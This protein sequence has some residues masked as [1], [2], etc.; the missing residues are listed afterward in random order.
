MADGLDLCK[1]EIFITVAGKTGSPLHG[2]EIFC[3]PTVSTK[4]FLKL[5]SQKYLAQIS[6]LGNRSF[7][8]VGDKSVSQS[9]ISQG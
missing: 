5:A 6:D 7:C 4:V 2:L 9:V 8:R 1:G 3:L